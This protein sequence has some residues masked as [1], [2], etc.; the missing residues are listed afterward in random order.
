MKKI[1][2][3]SGSP[4]RK[5]LLEQI[6]VSFTVVTSHADEIV[7]KKI[8]EEIVIELSALKAEAVYNSLGDKAQEEVLVIGADTIVYQDGSVLGKPQSVEQA[9]TMIK[10]ICGREHS[11]YTGV[12]IV[13]KGIHSS[14]YEKT[15]VSCYDMSDEEIDRYVALGEGMDKAGGYGIQGA[16]AAYVKGIAGDYNNVV[17]LPAARL[18]QELKKYY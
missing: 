11:V 18:Y 7:T 12:T 4:R 14:F 3:A 2:L 16:F 13:G 5:E 15:V 17:G 10:N 9:K 1:I 8:P 6:G